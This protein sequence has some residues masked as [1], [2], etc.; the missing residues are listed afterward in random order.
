MPLNTEWQRVSP[1]ATVYF[2]FKSIPHLVNLWPILIPA[3]AGG[4]FVQQLFWQYGLPLMAVLML[5]GVVLQYWFF[6]FR[7]E[8]GRINLRSGILNR[9]RLTLDFERVQQADIAHPFYFRPFQLATLGL[10]SAGSAQQEVDIPGIPTSLAETLRQQVLE[11]QQSESAPSEQ[12]IASDEAAADFELKLT[13]ADVARY[14]LMQNS[15][16]YL[17]PL[18]APLGQ[19]AGP[20]M[21]SALASIEHS[22]L[23]HWFEWASGN[24]AVS[25]GLILAVFAVLAGTSL[26][27]G[28]SVILALVRYWNYHLTRVGERYQYRAGLTTIRTRGFKIQ[29]LQ[30]VTVY[31]G[32]I[33]RLLSRF[34]VQISKA[35][36]IAQTG[37]VNQQKFLIPVL[38]AATLSG[39]KRELALP[40]PTWHSVHGFYWVKPLILWVPFCLSVT[41]IVY[42]VAGL[43]SLLIL[44]LLPVSLWV[45][46]RRWRWFGFY[47]DPQW[48]ALR[49]GFIGFSEHWLPTGKLQK[50][51]LSQSPVARKL[52]L[53]TVHVWSA[54]GRISIPCVPVEQAHKLR[55]SL[56]ADVVSFNSPWF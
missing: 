16:L 37:A 20:L 19:Q 43:L 56:L 42:A 8:Q 15:L 41:A 1:V 38:T 3:F 50:I 24:L 47:R 39:L 27:F 21:E 14:G 18:A 7:L 48:L 26:L 6:T 17:A 9:K 45:T 10:E 44:L 35:G 13:P 28:L 40:V 29:K 30:K 46:R 55:D 34:T 25:V 5:L 4:E 2:A 54:D 23:F 49:S 11:F 36:G 33:A 32:I 52:R 53:A 12:F 22:Q 51:T 31:Q